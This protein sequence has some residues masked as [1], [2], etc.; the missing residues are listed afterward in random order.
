MHGRERKCT[1]F[2]SK[3]VA[4]RDNF[5]D[6]IAV[7]KAILTLILKEPNLNRVSLV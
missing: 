4:G 2:Q 6:W 1:K 7:S 3:F 5:A